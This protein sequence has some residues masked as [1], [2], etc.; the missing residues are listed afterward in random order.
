MNVAFTC[1]L[2]LP[3]NSFWVCTHTHTCVYNVVVQ[4]PSHSR[5]CYPTDCSTPGLPVS[6][7]LPEFAQVHV[8]RIGDDLQL[9]HPLDALFSCVRSFPALGSFP[10]SQLFA[11]DAQNTG[12]SA[13]ALPGDIQGWFPLRSTSLISLLSK[14]LS[15]VFSSTTVQ[16]HKFF[17]VPPSLWSSSHYCTWPVGRP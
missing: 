3:G 14:G 17:G 10:V 4:S 15:G 5:L 8:H 6:H 12:I 11:S 16:K 7:G 9:S 1:D 2:V 13:S